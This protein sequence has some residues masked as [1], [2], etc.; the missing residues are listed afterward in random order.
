VLLL[1]ASLT[2]RASQAGSHQG[3]GWEQF[4]DQVVRILADQTIH[5]VF[6][7]WGSYA[8]KKGAV[9]DGRKHLIIR[10]A[11]PSPLSAHRGFFGSKPFSKTNQYLRQHGN[12]PIKW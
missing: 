8:Q 9:I 12:N 11:H 4:T 1:N 3:K 5:L 6:I 2:V 7:L 10:S